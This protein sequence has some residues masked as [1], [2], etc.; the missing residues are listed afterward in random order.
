M[1]SRL[2]FY[3][4]QTDSLINDG[5]LNTSDIYNLQ[6]NARMAVLSSCRSGTGILRRGE[7]LMSLARGFFYAGCPSV[8]LTLWEVE[9]KTGT[10]IMKEFYRNLKFGKPKDV[11]LRNA[12]LKYLSQADPMTSHPHF[13][14]GYITVGNPDPL[15]SGKQKY[16]LALMLF[17]LFWMTI[18]LAFRKKAGIHWQKTGAAVKKLKN[19]SFSLFKRARTR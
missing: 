13:W 19:Y 11:A 6:L 8:V 9:D 18:S 12:K 15:F 14:L 1:F 5:W 4:D 16:L 10:A 2:A 7:G 3:Q 17:I